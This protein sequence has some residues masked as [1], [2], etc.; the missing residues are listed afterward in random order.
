MNAIKCYHEIKKFKNNNIRTLFAS[1]GVKG[2]DLDPSYYIDNL[3]FEN[4]VNTAPL[5]TIKDW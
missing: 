4:S 2:N 5:A 1:T 3:I